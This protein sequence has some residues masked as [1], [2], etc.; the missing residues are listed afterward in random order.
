MYCEPCRKACDYKTSD[1]CGNRALPVSSVQQKLSPQVVSNR[2]ASR[3]NV[4]RTSWQ[5]KIVTLK[6]PV[7]NVI[8]FPWQVLSHLSDNNAFWLE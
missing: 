5:T 8:H 2:I 1:S 4:R 6:L 7:W 3:S